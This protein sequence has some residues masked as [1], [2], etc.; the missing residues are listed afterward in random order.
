M[1]KSIL[2]ESDQKV[3]FYDDASLMESHAIGFTDLVARPTR[4]C[5]DLGRQEM[6]DGAHELH[7]QIM[8]YNPSLMCI[9]GRGIWD[10]IYRAL[11]KHEGVKKKDLPDFGLMPV[12]FGKTRVFVVPSTSGLVREKRLDL[13]DELGLLYKVEREEMDDT[14]V[15]EQPLHEGSK[16]D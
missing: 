14:E 13:W 6:D 2:N 15:P 3:T 5:E 1:N 11:F 16:E 8:A 4:G 10:V 9:V 7:S 12:R